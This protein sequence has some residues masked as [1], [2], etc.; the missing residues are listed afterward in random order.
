MSEMECIDISLLEYHRQ[1]LSEC[2]R[3]ENVK[4]SWF[5][6]LIERY[7]IRDNDSILQDG[8]IVR[9][10]RSDTFSNPLRIKKDESDKYA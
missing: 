9:A 4:D 7:N 8:T 6:F 3:A 2:S 5:R 1:V 10:E